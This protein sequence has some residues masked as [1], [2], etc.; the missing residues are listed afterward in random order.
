MMMSGTDAALLGRVKWISTEEKAGGHT[1]AKKCWRK[2]RNELVLAPRRTG[3]KG[4]QLILH[5]TSSCR[6]SSERRVRVYVVIDACKRGV[7]CC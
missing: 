7:D 6:L 3:A 4:Q 5:Q 1:L 2:G